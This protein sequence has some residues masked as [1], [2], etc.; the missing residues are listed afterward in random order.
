[1]S[2]YQNERKAIETYFTTQWGDATPVGPDGQSFEPIAD[3]VRLT[4]NSG[5]VFQGSIGRMANRKDHVGTLVISIYTEGNLGSSAWRPYADTIID[6]LT[7]KTLTDAGIIATTT[8]GAFLR[9][10]PPQ[11][12]PNEHPYISASFK[13]APFHITNIT[14]PFIRYSYG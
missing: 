13:S 5:A 6:F 2:G 9:F 10:S 12:A 1:M 3:S 11:I 4:I 8:A 7:E 14:A